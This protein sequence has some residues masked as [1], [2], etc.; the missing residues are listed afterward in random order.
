MSQNNTWPVEKACA[1][2]APQPWACGFNHVPANI[3]NST[4][5]WMDCGFD[6][7]FFEAEIR[8]AKSAGFNC[9]RVFLPFIVWENEPDAFK[10]R[11][12]AYLGICH[13]HGFR[14]MPILFDDCT[15]SDEL[16]NPVF[17]KQP[18]MIPGWYA[19]TWTPSPGADIVRDSAQW[20]RLE[21][22]VKDVI[23]SFKDD[24]RVWIW[25]LYN[26]PT[27]R[28]S[29]GD[30]SLPLYE[31]VIAWAREVN[32]SQPLT[33]GVWNGNEKFN[34]IALE[35]SDIITFHCY[36]PPA[37]LEYLIA[38]LKKHGRPLVCTEW[39]Q[40]GCGGTVAACLPIF[41]RENVGA[42]HWGLVN[43]KLQTHLNWGHRPGDPD[44]AVCQHDLFR[45]NH[46][47]YDTE[48]IRLFKEATQRA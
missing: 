43:G 1:W 34:K 44:P 42:M 46:T 39:M 8:L 11:L 23:G 15:F 3:V 27:Q 17:G 38:E 30:E 6:P 28:A 24:P 47:P 29:L 48:E 32:P 20:P 13:R 31:N 45:G 41:K 10:A 7:A 36:G 19:N 22:Y 4:E 25:D 18:P 21:P 12:A 26:E 5:M 33:I 37:H 9:L 2:H 35:N 14:V 16:I 40:R